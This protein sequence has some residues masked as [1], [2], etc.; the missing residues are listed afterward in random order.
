MFIIVV[1]LLIKPIK[2]IYKPLINI[3]QVFYFEESFCL[4]PFAQASPTGGEIPLMLNFGIWS[5]GEV[6]GKLVKTTHKKKISRPLVID[7]LSTKPVKFKKNA[8]TYH[9]SDW[10]LIYELLSLYQLLVFFLFLYFS[11]VS[12]TSKRCINKFS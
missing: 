7:S 12:S 6:V 8:C 9:W 2:F 3:S 5:I 4:L 1:I 11:W 10:K